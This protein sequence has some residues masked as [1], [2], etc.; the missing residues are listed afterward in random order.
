M[1]SGLNGQNFAFSGYLPIEKTEKIKKIKWLEQQSLLQNQ[2]QIFMET[3]YRNNKFL[4]DLL[5]NLS[6]QTLLCIATDITLSTEYIKTQT[7][8][9]WK[10]N[11]VD[12]HHRPC[13]FLI[14]KL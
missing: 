14:Q 10:K 3:P 5:Q 8:N 2:T 6:G 12:L 11:K 7:V 1:S 9:D 4:E 13:I